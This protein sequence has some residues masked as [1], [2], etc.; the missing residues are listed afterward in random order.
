VNGW[1]WLLAAGA[2]DFTTGVLLAHGH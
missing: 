2:V 1:L